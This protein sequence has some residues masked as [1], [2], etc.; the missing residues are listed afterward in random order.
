[1]VLGYEKLT[2]QGGYLDEQEKPGTA[3]KGLLWYDIT[4]GL[5]HLAMFSHG[6][7]YCP[8]DF[9]FYPFDTQKCKFVMQG[10]RN[11]SHQVSFD[12]FFLM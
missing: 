6:N 7:I 2:L 11:A 5:F 3:G 9:A 12:N 1:M 8:M 4:K 10:S